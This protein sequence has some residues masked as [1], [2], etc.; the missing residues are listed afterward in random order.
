MSAQASNSD[1]HGDSSP[2]AGPSPRYWVFLSYSH[3]DDKRHRWAGY[4]ARRIEAFPI[5]RKLRRSREGLPV[6]LPARLR[7]FRDRDE[8]PTRG[9]LEEAVKESLDSAVYLVVLCSPGAAVSTYVAWE[10][11][12]FSTKYGTSRVIPFVIEGCPWKHRSRDVEGAECIPK[13]LLDLS[14]DEQVSK[15]LANNLIDATRPA[16]SRR[17]VLRSLLVQLLS[18]DEAEVRH[19]ERIRFVKRWMATVGLGLAIACG[20]LGFW[21]HQVA[22]Q[23]RELEVKASEKYAELGDEAAAEKNYARAL[24]FFAHTIR[25]NPSNEDAVARAQDILLRHNWPLPVAEIK[26]PQRS[27]IFPRSAARHP[28]AALSLLSTDGETLLVDHRTDAPSVVPIP[29]ARYLSTTCLSGDGD[30]VL[31]IQDGEVTKYSLAPQSTRTL[32]TVSGDKTLSFSCN[33]DGTRIAVVVGVQP[34]PDTAP[35]RKAGSESPRMTNSLLDAIARGDRGTTALLEVRRLDESFSVEMSRSVPDDSKVLFSPVDPDQLAVWD[36]HGTDLLNLAEGSPFSNVFCRGDGPTALSFSRNGHTLFS[37]LEEAPVVTVWDVPTGSPL[38]RFGAHKSRITALACSPDGLW[39]AT[40]S[41]DGMVYLWDWET[42]EI[43]P[44]AIQ[45]GSAVRQIA[46][47]ADGR[48]IFVRGKGHT[49]CAWNVYSRQPAMMAV[50]FPDEVESFMISADGREMTTFNEKGTVHRWNIHP[51]R[52]PE[53]GD[54]RGA[55]WKPATFDGTYQLETNNESGLLLRDEMSGETRQLVCDTAER[56]AVLVV[57][58]TIGV[59]AAAYADRTVRTW[60]LTTGKPLTGSL[61]HRLRATGLTLGE[62]GALLVLHAGADV[63]DAMVSLFQDRKDLLPDDAPSDRLVMSWALPFTGPASRDERLGLAAVSEA[64]SGWR[65]LAD[66]SMAEIPFAERLD[67]F[68]ATRACVASSSGTRLAMFLSWVVDDPVSRTATPWSLVTFSRWTEDR[69][70]A[71]SVLDLEAALDVRPF[72][73]ESLLQMAQRLVEILERDRDVVRRRYDVRCTAQ[74]ARFYAGLSAQI[75]PHDG[76][77]AT[78]VKEVGDRLTAE[79]YIPAGRSVLGLG[80][81]GFVAAEAGQW[82]A[83]VSAWKRA[84]ARCPHSLDVLFDRFLAVAHW[85]LGEPETAA[86]YYDASLQER[87]GPEGVQDGSLLADGDVPS[88][89]SDALSAIRRRAAEKTGN[90]E[91]NQ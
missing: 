24:S 87:L 73:A 38:G 51:R 39:V 4:L 25:M 29:H 36:D 42:Q 55:G 43:A 47:G 71:S 20:F 18:V 68:R 31:T 2:G 19:I 53:L 50:R 21:R 30:S 26:P 16:R 60:S 46:F 91:S 3:G 35:L 40:G 65:I 52:S 1:H 69:L 70:R 6:P 34:G 77:I 9:S 81:E 76:S 27:S 28:N 86:R 61:T 33:A 74:T 17:A 88:W 5:P 13:S 44:P 79:G 15:A 12:I 63:L 23:A 14:S 89:C 66:G 58:R 45:V 56:Q 48:T 78:R 8:L 80:R 10:A 75:A 22:G 82:A 59:A 67:A 7:V 84:R 72:Q 85:H 49:I 37:A 90:I 41:E 57:S 54:L 83:A 64:V 62:D 32:G 11:Q